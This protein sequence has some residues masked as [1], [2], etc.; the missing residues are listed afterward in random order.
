MDAILLPEA[1]RHATNI[2][3]GGVD[4][5]LVTVIVG[6]SISVLSTALLLQHG[7]QFLLVGE[8]GTPCGPLGPALVGGLSSAGSC[9]TMS[10]K[11]TAEINIGRQGYVPLPPRGQIQIGAKVVLFVIPLSRQLS[12]DGGGCR[13]GSSGTRQGHGR[14]ARQ[15]LLQRTL[16][17]GIESTRTAISADDG[18]LVA[19]AATVLLGT[20][21]TV[22]A[23]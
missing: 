6:F 7:L 23:K 13:S 5:A 14:T 22:A 1:G 10:L 2:A 11:A 20:R 16:P 15:L 17:F 4:S 12:R 8:D 21:A 18:I 19:T 9:A 3:R